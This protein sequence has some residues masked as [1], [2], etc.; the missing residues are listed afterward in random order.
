MNEKMLRRIIKE[1][2]KR[3]VL[4]EG[5]GDFL[6]KLLKK[7]FKFDSDPSIS[8]L[9]RAFVFK[10]NKARKTFNALKEAPSIKEEVSRYIKDDDYFNAMKI[11]LRVSDSEMKEANVSNDDYRYLKDGYIKIFSLHKKKNSLF[12]WE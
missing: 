11:V 8:D 12:D 6:I 9:I 5:L 10:N 1:E 3:E 2:L 7:I 4:N